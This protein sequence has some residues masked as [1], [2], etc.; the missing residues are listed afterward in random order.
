MVTQI[1]PQTTI[2]VIWDFDD[3]LIPGSMQKPIFEK[4]DINE[5]DFWSEVNNLGKHYAVKKTKINQSTA[6]LNHILTYV[7]HEEFHGLNNEELQIL[8]AEIEFFQAVPEFFQLLKNELLTDDYFLKH[9][10]TVE[11]YIVSTGLRRM[12]IGSKISPYVDDIWGCEFIEEVASPRLFD[13][14]TA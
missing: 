5:K 4:Y 6:Y 11:L 9:E 10:I 3:T 7:K 12:I 14:Q 8:G 2:A 1:F 13:Q